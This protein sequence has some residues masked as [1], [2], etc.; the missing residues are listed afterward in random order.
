MYLKIEELIDLID[1][2]SCCL[3][4]GSE[5]KEGRRHPLLVNTK[6]KFYLVYSLCSGYWNRYKALTL[7]T[8]SLSG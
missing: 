4:A 6:Y 7:T 8:L 3:L 2:S 1:A 5:E